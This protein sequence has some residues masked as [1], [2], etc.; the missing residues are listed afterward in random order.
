MSHMSVGKVRQ[1][2]AEMVNRVA[3][4]GDRVV[5]ERR[6]KGVAALI[7][8]DDLELLESLEDREDIKAARRAREQMKRTGEKPVPWADLKDEL[9]L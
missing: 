9:G 7:S 3:Y 5:I 2:I 6:G 4:G 1:D 8:L